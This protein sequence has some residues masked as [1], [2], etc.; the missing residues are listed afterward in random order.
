MADQDGYL[1]TE[2]GVRLYFTVFGESSTTVVIPGAAWAAADL[3]P[4]ARNHRLVFYDQRGR[5]RSDAVADPSKIGIE[6]EVRDLE[7]V[8]LNLKLERLSLMGWSYLG[9][10]VALYAANHPMR[11][12]HL[13]LMCSMAPRPVQTAHY[14][15]QK[16]V[17]ELD[18][19]IDPV[20]VARLEKLRTSGLS[21]RDPAA[22]CREHV[23][24]HRVFQMGDPQA[25]TRM[26]SDPCACL[27]EWPDNLAR[28]RER[29]FGSLN[30]YDWRPAAQS[31]AAP[32]LVVHGLE[33]PIPL[34]ASQ[35]WAASFPNARLLVIPGSGHYPHLERPDLL[36]PALDHF[37]SGAWPQ[38]AERVTARTAEDEFV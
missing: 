21:E 1:L 10:V 18:A 2:D 15:G 9:G 22:F 5:G 3:A 32:T 28:W 36:F 37:Y 16:P 8:R 19:R 20:A 11:V 4:L 30:G 33:D 13:C 27:N 29:L 38:D 7:A 12:E 6:H 35:E 34:G 24:V 17:E 25:F 26:R 14:S 31:V 23:K